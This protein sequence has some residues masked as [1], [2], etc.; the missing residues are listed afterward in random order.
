M[1]MTGWFGLRR[2]LLFVLSTINADRD[3]DGNYLIFG[4][5]IA[6]GLDPD[7]VVVPAGAMYMVDGR[8]YSVPALLNSTSYGMA[9]TVIS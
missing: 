8:A 9:V 5:P 4:D 7:E 2:H 1:V 3:E 6:V